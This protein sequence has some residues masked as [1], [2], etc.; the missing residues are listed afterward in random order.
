MSKPVEPDDMYE[1]ITPVAIAC[2]NSACCTVTGCAPTSS[3][4]LAVTGL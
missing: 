1:S 2:A 3:A 4:I